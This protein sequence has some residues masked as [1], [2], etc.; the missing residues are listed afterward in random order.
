ME[1]HVWIL[2]HYAQEPGGAG[3]TRHYSLAKHL[4]SNGWKASVIA[5]SVELNTG[6]QRLSGKEKQ[7]KIDFDGVTFLWVRT[8]EYVGNGG[9]RMKNM[10]VYALHVLLPS[11]TK[12][13][14]RPDVIVGSSVHPFAAWSAAILARRFRVP[15]IFEV[16]D[17]W[18]QTL[19]DMGRLRA[20]G[21]VTKALRKLENWLYHR[22]DRIVVLLPQAADYIVPLGVAVDKIVWIPNGV[23]LDGYPEPPRPPVRDSFT[24]MYFGAHGQA[25]G[26]DVL[27]KA[28]A[29]LKQ[30]PEM[31]HVRLRLIG[32]G[33]LKPQLQELARDLDLNNVDF[34]APVP[35][36]QIPAL[37]AEA[38][39]F[40]ISVLDL[41]Q[42]Y[43]YGISMNKLFDY[44]AAARPI[45]IASS[46]VN[47]PVEEAEAGVSVRPGDSVALSKAIESLVLLPVEQRAAMGRAGRAYVEKNHDFRMLAAKLAATLNDVVAERR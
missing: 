43:R 9:G 29:K 47:D 34:G 21:V 3:G 36:Q 26:L 24:L 45:I 2:N 44:F 13:L 1:K 42:L 20:D 30:Q 33:P 27:L 32:D 46:A 16:R 28:M 39:A 7:K 35:K 41:P 19:V 4:L 12:D 31:S 38:D 5:S 10:L 14:E 8:P 22:A 17:L 11:V 25:N 15:F 37:A 6:H 18:P 40:V 23:E